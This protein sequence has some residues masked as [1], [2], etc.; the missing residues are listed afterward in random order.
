ML[1]Q[2]AEEASAKTVSKGELSLLFEGSS[3]TVHERARSWRRS[4]A[5]NVPT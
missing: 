2:F 5:S 3:F 1:L 4:V